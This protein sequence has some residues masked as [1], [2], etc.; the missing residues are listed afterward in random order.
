MLLAKLHLH[1]TPR[2]KFLF[3]LTYGHDGSGDADRV[4]RHFC[5]DDDV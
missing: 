1:V 3:K 2:I 4:G 5:T